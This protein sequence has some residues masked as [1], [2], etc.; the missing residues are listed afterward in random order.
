MSR[1]TSRIQEC[2]VLL[3]LALTGC[4]GN[5]VYQGLDAE[6]LFR[7]AQTEFDEGE[8]DN[9][10]AA[11]ERLMVSF[12]SSD[13]LPEGRFLLAR[14]YFE[15]G[16]FITAR[17]EYQR[18]LDRY[19]GHASSPAAALGICRSLS[20]LVPHPQRDQSYTRDAISACGNVIVDYAG[21][22]EAT[23]AA[24]IRQQMRETI[25]EKEYLNA[26]GYLRRK[27]YDPAIIYF[28]FVVD[29]YPETPFAPQALLGIYRAN[30]AIGYDDLAEEARSRL[31][32]EYPD[33]EAAAQLVA[34]TSGV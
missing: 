32:L 33:S 22:E 19:V 23:V 16:E 18:F 24:G 10:I 25:A 7:T 17:A 6:T 5:D 26:S 15:K 12:Q 3:A 31:L 28:Q 34:D 8:Y 11:L 29:S 9:S 4:G 21:T 14:S 20:G 30:E 1:I 27:Q 13:R 2:V